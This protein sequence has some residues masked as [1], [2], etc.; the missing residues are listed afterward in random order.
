MDGQT[1]NHLLV[2]DQRCYTDRVELLASGRNQLMSFLSETDCKVVGLRISNAQG[3]RK[4]S[5]ADAM[6]YAEIV[7]DWPGVP[8]AIY[9][10]RGFERTS[11]IQTWGLVSSAKSI[12]EAIRWESVDDTAWR[13]QF[14]LAPVLTSQRVAYPTVTELGKFEFSFWRRGLGGG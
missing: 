8:P 13:A 10:A 14:K 9:W 6:L 1:L 12:E 4:V 7:R 5:L 3:C 2:I 11:G